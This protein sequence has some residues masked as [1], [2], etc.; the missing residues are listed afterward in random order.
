MLFNLH[1]LENVL[2]GNLRTG[3][4]RSAFLEHLGA[5][6]LKISANNG[7]GKG[8]GE[9]QDVTS[10][11]KKTLDTSLKLN[12]WFICKNNVSGV[13]LSENVPDIYDLSGLCFFFFPIDPNI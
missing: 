10:L 6:D 2:Q 1:N 8:E 13:T 12:H 3:T 4:T 5:Q 9:L 7:G 11:P